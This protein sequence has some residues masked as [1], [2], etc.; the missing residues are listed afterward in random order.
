[1]PGKSFIP[2][3]FVDLLTHGCPAVDRVFPWLPVVSSNVLCRY[4]DVFRTFGLC[5]NSQG[6]TVSAQVEHSL[7]T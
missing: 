2:P 7:R 5:L 6:Q 1:M 3:D 4:S